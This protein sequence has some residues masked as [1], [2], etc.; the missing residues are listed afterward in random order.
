[1]IIISIADRHLSRGNVPKMNKND[2]KKQTR[3]YKGSFEA[4]I[5]FWTGVMGYICCGVSD[6]W[7]YPAW[8]GH[9][10]LD[11]RKLAIENSQ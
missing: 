9:R 1:M 11:K 8:L 2:S 5:G 7:L 4:L 3:F 10:R 6:E